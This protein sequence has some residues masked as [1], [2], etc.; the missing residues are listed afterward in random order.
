MSKVK[1]ETIANLDDTK[2]MTVT[3]LVDGYR[4]FKNVQVNVD[5]S[6]TGVKTF[7]IPHGLPSIPNIRDIALSL[8]KS[9]NVSDWAI[10]YMMLTNTDATN[11][12]GE[13][14]V[15]QA[16]ATA[17]STVTVNAILYVPL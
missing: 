9:S 3:Q 16:S 11:I 5:I 4:T 7:N 12:T 1:V 17:S 2:Q 6:S 8:V 14:R 15:S 10:A 13:L